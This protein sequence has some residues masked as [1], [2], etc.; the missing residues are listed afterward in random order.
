MCKIFFKSFFLD[1]NLGKNLIDLNSQRPFF[2]HFI[3]VPVHIKPF[4]LKALKAS[5]N[6]VLNTS[7]LPDKHV[8][9]LSRLGLSQQVGRNTEERAT[10][11]RAPGAGR[12]GDRD[13]KPGERL[14]HS[15]VDKMTILSLV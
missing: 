4:L 6:S 14:N 7:S 2:K 10:A 5:S 15:K 1:R 11:V 8:W 9:V 3:Q 12:P 13:T